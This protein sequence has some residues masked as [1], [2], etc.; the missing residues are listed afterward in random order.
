MATFGI[1]AALIAG[2]VLL[3]FVLSIVRGLVFA[4]LWAWFVMPFGAPAIGIAHAI[5]L[6]VLVTMLTG[7]RAKT[8]DDG[9]KSLSEF[10][11]TLA[12]GIGV[13]LCALGIGYVAHNF[14]AG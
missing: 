1:V 3:L 11:K 6:A 2:I 8:D 10:G 12:Y 14:M 4:Q 7:Q 9:E 13:P 5:G